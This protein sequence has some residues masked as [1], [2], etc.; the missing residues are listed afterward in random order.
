[1]SRGA[2]DLRQDFVAGGNQVH[3]PASGGKL[4]FAPG[5]IVRCIAE[6]A[7]LAHVDRIIDV[8]YPPPAEA[9]E[10]T[11]LRRAQF[12]LMQHHHV[13]FAQQ[14]AALP[15]AKT[16][17]TAREALRPHLP[18]GR[19]E[20]GDERAHAVPERGLLQIVAQQYGFRHGQDL[21]FR[22]TWAQAILRAPESPP[23]HR[24]Q[25]RAGRRGR[26]ARRAAARCATVH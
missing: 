1:M 24:R 21:R 25:A 20:R 18:A 13:R 14:R 9:G 22:P 2:R 5:R 17:A 19:L 16:V 15:G 3:P 26:Q 4:S 10:Q 6:T 11:R 23:R 12:D 7:R 8:E